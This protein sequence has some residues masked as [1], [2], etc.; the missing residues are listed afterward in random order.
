M[1]KT[2]M[3]TII[4]TKKSGTKVRHSVKPLQIIWNKFSQW[5]SRNTVHL[6]DLSRNF[7]LNLSNGLKVSAYYR[8]KSKGKRDVELAGLSN[9]LTRL[10]NEVN[11][12]TKVNFSKWKEVLAGD[13]DMI[14]YDEKEDNKSS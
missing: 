4:S 3:F 5:D 13:A 1:D 14:A 6:D 7:A 10:A 2:S 12:F 11:D 8:K 9:Y